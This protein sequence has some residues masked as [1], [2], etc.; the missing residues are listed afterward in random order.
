MG[1]IYRSEI[2]EALMLLGCPDVADL[3][4]SRID[5]PAEW[6]RLGASTA[7]PEGMGTA[8]AGS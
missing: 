4:R 2:D 8:G 1:E 3:V 7:A 5:Y 6:D